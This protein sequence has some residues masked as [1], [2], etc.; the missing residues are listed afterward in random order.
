MLSLSHQVRM[1]KSSSRHL[2]A[3][4]ALRMPRSENS[5]H[6]LAGS[7][8]LHAAGAPSAWLER[9]WTHTDKAA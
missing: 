1:Q 4:Q 8:H 6:S 2:S 3:G 7:S 9:F 5:G